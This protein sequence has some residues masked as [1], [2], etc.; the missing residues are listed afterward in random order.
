MENTTK[1]DKIDL[2]HSVISL[3][4]GAQYLARFRVTSHAWGKL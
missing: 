4:L 3:S 1:I 2:F